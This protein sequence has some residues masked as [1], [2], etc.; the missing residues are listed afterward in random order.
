[1]KLPINDRLLAC[2]DFIHPGDRVADVGCDHGYLGIHLLQTGVAAS[3]IASDLREGPL[4]SA[5]KNAAKYGLSDK[6][7]FFLSDGVQ[8]IP[9]NFDVLVCAGMGADTMISILTAAPWLKSNQYRLILQCQTKTYLLRQYLSEQGYA[10]VRETVQRDGKFLYTIME[11]QWNPA[12][13]RLTP[14]GFYFPPALLES[15]DDDTREYCR[16]IYRELHKI[17]T[18]RGDAASETMKTALAEIES[19]PGLAFVKEEIL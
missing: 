19:R 8:T 17:V 10:I 16:W 5:R 12:A 9:R 11:I 3:V 15:A 18:S 4:D 2:C 7:T 13:P 1:M 6:M 14:G